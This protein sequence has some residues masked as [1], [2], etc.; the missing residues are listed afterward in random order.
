MTPIRII[1]HIV[2][3]RRQRRRIAERT[4]VRQLLRVAGVV[5][6]A[7]LI[8]ITGTGVAS[9]SAVVGAYAYFTRD[10]PAPEQI[11]AAERNFETTKVY[12]RT[13]QILLYEVIDP[14]GGDRTW[15][16]LDQMPEDVV[17][18]T[19]ALEVRNYWENPGVNMRG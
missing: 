8:V 2:L 12:D 10:L 4:G 7:V 17:C 13:G 11:E 15:L 5:L 9:A 16:A 19:V 3:Q 14:T 18:A 1:R 6:L